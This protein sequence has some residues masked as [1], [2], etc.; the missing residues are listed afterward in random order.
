MKN[1]Y[2]ARQ[3]FTGSQWLN[4]SAVMVENDIVEEVISLSMLPPET[5]ISLH[6]HYLVP[7]FIDIQIYGAYSRLLSVAADTDTLQK[8]NDYCRFGGAKYFLPTISTNETKVLHNGIDAVRKYWKNGGEGVYGLHIEG[9]WINKIKRGAHLEKLIHAPTIAEVTSLLEY[10]KGVIKMI[11]VAPEVCTDEV[12]Q[13]LKSYGIIISAGHSNA[14]YAEAIR[15]LDL[16]IPVATHLFNAM[17]SLHHREPGFAAAVL[18]H[19]SVMCSLVPDGF[20]VNF[21]MIRFAKKL[22]AERLFIITDAVTETSEGPYKHTLVGDKYETNGILSGSAL[23]MIKGVKNLVQN[24]EISIEEALK[25]ASLYPAKVLGIDYRIG[26]IEKGFNA[27]MVML[28]ENLDVL[29]V[30]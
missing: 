15:G 29:E 3:I 6:A 14:T 20:H 18:L 13:L 28:N 4:D 30:I 8:M 24:C 7:A 26:K 9:P 16:G 17:T 10:G 1:F 12:I 5:N 21:E 25:M 23:T 11:T 27:D 2:S 22:M 19:P